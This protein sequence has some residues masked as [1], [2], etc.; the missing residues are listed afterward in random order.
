VV[1]DLDPGEGVAFSDVVRAALDVRARLQQLKLESFCRTTGGRGLHVVLPVQ[2]VVSWDGVR[3][4]A[5]DFAHAMQAD[6]PE[7]YVATLPKQQRRGHILVD[8]LR[9][10]L[11]A[12]SVASF[13]PRARPGAAVA[14]PL[15]W[16]EVTADLDPM[17]FSIATVPARLKRQKADPWDGFNALDQVVPTI[18]AQPTRRR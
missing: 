13:S 1:F 7:H 4:F 2:P 5:H 9:N 6:S 18:Q 3:A 16:G 8:W 14:T 12:T 11:G 15:A 17:K 10:G